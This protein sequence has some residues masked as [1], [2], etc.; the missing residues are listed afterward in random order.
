MGCVGAPQRGGE[1][2]VVP[3]LTAAEAEL[4]AGLDARYQ[5]MVLRHRAAAL[6]AGLPYTIISGLRSRSQQAALATSTARSTPAAPA[7]LSKHEVGFA[8][9][10]DLTTDAGRPIY[11][12]A[13]LER[14]GVLWEQLGGRWGGRFK[15]TPDLNHFEAPEPRATLAA[16]RNVML[17]AG[18][19]FMVAGVWVAVETGG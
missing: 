12:P 15:P 19:G 11:T 17:A 2:I 7:G 18:V 13:Q 8:H 6:D 3:P 4:V 10:V 5:P 1:A 16:Y 14:L 9:D